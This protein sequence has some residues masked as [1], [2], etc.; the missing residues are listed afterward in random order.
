LKTIEIVVAPDGS[1]RIETRG[2]TGPECRLASAF[3]EKSL[4]R[5][6]SEQLTAAFHQVASEEGRLAEDS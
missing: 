1:S 2:Y 4:G 6:S 5:Q 3:L